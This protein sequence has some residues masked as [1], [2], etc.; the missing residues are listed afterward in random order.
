[1]FDK[2]T[3]VFVVA[4]LAVTGANFA[5]LVSDT[6]AMSLFILLPTVG[7]AYSRQQVCRLRRTC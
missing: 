4:I 7:F 6:L 3:F 1:M 2:V 5:G